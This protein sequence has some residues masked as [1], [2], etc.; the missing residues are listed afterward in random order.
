MRA[1]SLTSAGFA[2][3]TLS[4][5]AFPASSLL[6]I[7]AVTPLNYPESFSCWGGVWLEMPWPVSFNHA[8][9]EGAPLKPQYNAILRSSK[10]V[11]IYFVYSISICYKSETCWEPSE[12]HWTSYYHQSISLPKAVRRLSTVPMQ[13]SGGPHE[14]RRGLAVQHGLQ[15]RAG[16]RVDLDG[17]QL[18]APGS[19]RRR[20]RGHGLPQ[21]LHAAART[22]LF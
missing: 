10:G 16:V 1:P 21:R 15:H 17:G 3:K 13:V 5:L 14:H 18:G 22:P 19:R 4:V 20:G 11:I 12:A 9:F 7:A 8:F 6:C 2:L